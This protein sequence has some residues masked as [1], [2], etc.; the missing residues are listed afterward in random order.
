MSSLFF[1]CVFLLNRMQETSK[2]A[3]YWGA[4]GSVWLSPVKCALKGY[5][6]PPV[7]KYSSSKVSAASPLG[8]Y[9]YT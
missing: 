9:P 3:F 2:L 4:V 8:L 6:K 5:Q 1:L 7:E